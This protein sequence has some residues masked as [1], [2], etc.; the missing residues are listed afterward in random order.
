MANKSPSKNRPAGLS[1][2][3]TPT[4]IKG[5]DTILNG[6]Y[7]TSRPTILRGASGTGKTLFSLNFA[8]SLEKLKQPVIYATF[9]ESPEN[10]EQLVKTLGYSKS[11]V[12]LDFTT[13]KSMEISGNIELGGLLARI[14]LAIKNRSAVYLI[15]DALDMLFAAFGDSEQVRRDLNRLFDWCRTRSITL[16]A[17]TGEE[18][19]YREG[20]SFMGYASDCSIRL[21][22]NMENDIMTRKVHVLKCRGRSHGTNNY[23]FIIDKRG[24]GIMPVTD[25]VMAATGKRRRIST[26]L[27]SLDSMLGGKGLW[28]GNTAMISGE[29]GTG[30][31][32]LAMQITRQVCG[33]GL[34]TL[35]CSFEEPATQLV[36]DAQSIGI[37]LKPHLK[38]GILN[39]MSRRSV[40]VGLEQHII[41]VLCAIEDLKPEVVV[42]DP[43]TALSD[44]GDSR[45]FKNT[46][47]RLCHIIKSLG[48]TALLTELIP[49]DAGGTSSMN[50]SSLVDT[51]IRL[52]RMETD[53]ELTRL[54][55]IHRSR[56][57]ATDN[58]VREL[59]ISGN[60]L[61][62]N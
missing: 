20:T 51:W 56:G 30:K 11:P 41:H 59:L 23:P 31:S 43:I 34:K 53:R 35:F 25:T 14:E 16:L 2:L 4:G 47:I 17:T 9:D 58:R 18:R 39:I 40:E 27:E 10:L 19:D 46:V 12:F 49:D 13:D 21:Q 36:R 29:S 24:I 3:S 62:V 52:R 55:H 45:N 7:P 32:L 26:G 50:V 54:I 60:G 48:V 1:A 22:Q 42:L 5:L 57:S 44:M 33:S 15:L 37:K 28:S 6:G 38:S 8:C 61:E